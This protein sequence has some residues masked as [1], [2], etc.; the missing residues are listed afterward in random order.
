MSDLAFTI[1]RLGFLVLLWVMVFAAVATL[2]KDIYGTVVTPRGKGRA[3]A[4]QNTKAAGGTDAASKV[5]PTELSLLVTGGPLTGTLLPLHGGQTV[6][7]GRSPASTLVLDDKYASG[8]HA[9][10]TLQ[11]D[12]WVLTD[13]GSTNGTFV[14]QERLSA[15]VVLVPGISV[16]VGQT[17]FELV[18]Q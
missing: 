15:P 4:R 2:R 7:I 3:R 17:T 13:L 14:D 1:F 5:N 8:N 16:R 12:S 10:L 18:R 6:T 11:G 9:S